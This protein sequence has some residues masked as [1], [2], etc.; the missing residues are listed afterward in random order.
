VPAPTTVEAA[1]ADLPRAALGTLLHLSDPDGAA[2]AYRTLCA[3]NELHGLD[4]YVWMYY[5]IRG[6][7]RQDCFAERERLLMLDAQTHF[8]PKTAFERE[9]YGKA[10]RPRAKAK[11]RAKPRLSWPY[12]RRAAWPSR[13]TSAVAY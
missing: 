3:V 13:R 9:Q 7:A 6:I 4:M 2:V 10:K 11:P 5:L 1:K 8:I 12:S